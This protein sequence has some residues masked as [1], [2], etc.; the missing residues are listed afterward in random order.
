MSYALEC[1]KLTTSHTAN[2]GTRTRAGKMLRWPR[3][4]NLLKKLQRLLV[5]EPALS[6]V[7]RGYQ[8]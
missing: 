2:A 3:F 5:D 6:H 1:E 8:T 7:V 4:L